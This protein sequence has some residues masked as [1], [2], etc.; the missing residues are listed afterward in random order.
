M[1]KQLGRWKCAT[2][3]IGARDD[4]YL[5]SII[6]APVRTRTHDAASRTLAVAP[7]RPR[8]QEPQPGQ[9]VCKLRQNGETGA[10]SGEDCDGRRLVIT[11]GGDNSFEVRHARND[12]EQDPDRIVMQNPVSHDADAGRVFEARMSAALSPS[13]AAADHGPA[14]LRGLQALLS[15]HYRR[16]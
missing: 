8:D 6:D 7:R 5:P 4:A 12:E 15:S 14:R 3:L 10:W 13:G 9:L 16:S 1:A 2:S 11:R